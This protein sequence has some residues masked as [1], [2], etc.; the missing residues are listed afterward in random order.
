[1]FHRLL[2]LVLV[3]FVTSFRNRHGIWSP[4]RIPLSGV[5]DDMNWD[6]TSAP[7][8]DFNEDYYTVVEV[9]PEATQQELKRAYYKTVFR[10]HPDK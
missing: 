2:A 1:M 3:T 7:K 8:L 10:F 5:A 4:I 6:P 9:D